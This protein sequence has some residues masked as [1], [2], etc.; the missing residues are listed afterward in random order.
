MKTIVSIPFVLIDK[1][2]KIIC[3]HVQGIKTTHPEKDIRRTE[4][5][6]FRVW[7]KQYG[8]SFRIVAKIGLIG[9]TNFDAYNLTYV[10]L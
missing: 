8:N 5:L 2:I 3:G 9:L 10:V 1:F 6:F 4:N 7:D